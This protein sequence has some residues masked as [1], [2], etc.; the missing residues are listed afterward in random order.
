MQIRGVKKETDNKLLTAE[1]F[2]ESL[3]TSAD[4]VH[5]LG[6]E[7]KIKRVAITPRI[8]RYKSADLRKLVGT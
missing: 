2:A 4:L 3:G 5:K 6:R 1:Q 7:G 8:I